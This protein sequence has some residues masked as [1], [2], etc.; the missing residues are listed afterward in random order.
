M[1]IDNQNGEIKWLVEGPFVT[2]YS[3]AILN[4]QLAS[5]LNKQG[6][7]VALF[8]REGLS[9]ETIDNISLQN[10]PQAK[11]FYEKSAH[12]TH[13]NASVV[14]RN[15]FPPVVDDMTCAIK[16]LHCYN[17]E[18][19]TFPIKWLKAFNA[20]LSGI[21]VSSK[22]VFNVLQNNGISVPMI[23][24]GVG[25]DH[26]EDVL[27]DSS[28]QIL[29]NSTKSFNFLHVSSFFPRKGPD[30]L[31]DAYGR[32]FTGDDD[33]CLLIKTFPNPH[34]RIHEQLINMREK[35]ANY[36]NVLVIERDLT[37][38][39]MKALYSQ[40]D[41]LVAP[42]CAEGFGLPLAEAML[43]GLPVITTGWSG[44]MDF[45]NAENSWLVDYKFEQAKTHFQLTPSAWAACDLEGLARAMRTSFNTSPEIRREMAT[46]G[47]ELLLKD[48]TWEV[49]AK[50]LIGFYRACARNQE[51]GKPKIGWVTTWNTQC[52]IATYSQHILDCFS[53]KPLI[54]SA[55]NEEELIIGGIKSI[56]CWNTA[57][58][59]DLFSLSDQLQKNSIDILVIQFNF[60]FF[61]SEKLGKFIKHEL[62]S[63]RKIVIDLHSTEDPPY[64]PHKLIKD[65]I[66]YFEC[67]DKLIVHTV[68][69]LNRMKNLG[70][71]DNVVLIP[72]GVM[73]VDDFNLGIEKVP[74]IATYGF[75]L[76][77]KGLLE[78]IEAVGLLKLQ[79]RH[80]FLKMIN[81]EYPTEASSELVKNIRSK[82]IKLD[83]GDQIF[84]ESRF[85][86]DDES[87]Y[88]LHRS[89]LLVFPYSPVTESASG[90]V[91]YGLSIKKPVLASN[92]EIFEE[93]GGAI[94][95]VSDLSPAG[96]A[97]RI[98]E[99][100][101]LVRTNSNNY[102]EKIHDI[103][104]WCHQ[105]YYPD[106]AY[107]FENILHSMHIQ[108][109]SG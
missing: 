40:C 98:W 101:N 5:A 81:A 12:I 30:V 92:T 106:I 16:M 45:C 90:A 13:L 97:D 48:F 38:G 23:I 58:E 93:F 70:V 75:C 71:I 86:S 63:M 104:K 43:S 7:N 96:L 52:G 103:K 29:G 19:T 56:G 41:V 61:N 11:A 27:A 20:N 57:D 67:V 14:S 73:K 39:E 34:N 2:S 108:K 55:N 3:L 15:H 72:H 107:K 26:W 77:H 82:I 44:Q 51:C 50:R 47:R 68:S 91:R 74:T 17:W 4:R 83:L 31:L 9:D 76:P 102:Q 99:V 79:G 65:Y 69:D 105:H 18:E 109:T 100:L 36:P 87:L 85:L 94:W 59:E 53:S 66:P 32:A 10:L 62:N 6:V 84:F 37:D 80:I 24:S 46:K 25:V 35:Y 78:I 89:D 21:A 54:F 42:S 28:F 64:A 22:H 8:A 60:N 33:V 49:V 95:R 88:H 1:F